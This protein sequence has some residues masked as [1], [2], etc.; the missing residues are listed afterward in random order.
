M[1]ARSYP[2]SQP[3]ATLSPIRDPLLYRPRKC[4][5]SG[6]FHRSKSLTQPPSESP[7]LF[8]ACTIILITTSSPTSSNI[9]SKTSKCRCS[10]WDSPSRTC[11]PNK[12]IKA[13][14]QNSRCPTRR[15]KQPNSW[16]SLSRRQLRKSTSSNKRSSRG[17]LDLD[18]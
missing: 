8:S 4:W 10:A 5:I 11:F 16:A 13:S 2:R 14:S 6:P 1:H 7:S 15:S 18:R 3:S 9:Y 12:I 17:R